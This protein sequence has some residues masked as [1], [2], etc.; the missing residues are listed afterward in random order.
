MDTSQVFSSFMKATNS[1]MCV[2]D[3]SGFKT[4]VH[5]PQS[6]AYWVALLFFL[7]C[8]G[9]AGCYAMRT[10]EQPYGETDLVRS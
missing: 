7:D 2:W 8:S 6:G 1:M 5:S 9:E 3:C 10:L 4:G